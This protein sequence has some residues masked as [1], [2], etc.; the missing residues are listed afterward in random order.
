MKPAYVSATLSPAEPDALVWH[1]KRFML[2]QCGYRRVTP[3][4]DVEKMT[5]MFGAQWYNDPARQ[6]CGARKFH[7]SG[8]DFWRAVYDPDPSRDPRR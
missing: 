8:H 2:P 1:D 6:Q 5:Q 3:P 4:E 7:S